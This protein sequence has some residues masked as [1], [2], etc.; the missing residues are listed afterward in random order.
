MGHFS[1][2]EAG[3]TCLPVGGLKKNVEKC[4]LNHFLYVTLKA[5]SL[6]IKL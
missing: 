6:T 2:K 1:S 5:V 4:D 3:F